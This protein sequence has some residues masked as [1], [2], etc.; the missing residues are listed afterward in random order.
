M[1]SNENNK[2]D[3]VTSQ[4]FEQLFTALRW[5]LKKALR[6]MVSVSDADEIV[7]DS[8][9]ALME[10][11]DKSVPDNPRAFVYTVARNLAI[12]RLRS[13]GVRQQFLSEQEATGLELP[14]NVSQDTLF[15][16]HQKQRLTA[17]IEQ[18]PPV[19]RQVFVLRKMHG[20]SHKEIADIMGI[21]VKT[22]ENHI[23]KGMK[24]C[25]QACRISSDHQSID[26]ARH[27]SGK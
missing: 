16:E 26:K 6:A 21:S 20:Y 2:A 4:W 25:L 10:Q 27:Q 5:P 19:C 23:A 11:C 3:S 9:V 22:V 18:L 17:A 24:A 15:A 7:Q 13:Q 14:S 1:P 8:F 12:S